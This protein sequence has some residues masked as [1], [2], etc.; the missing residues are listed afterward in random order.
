MEGKVGMRRSQEGGGLL[1]GFEYATG[2]KIEGRI[3]TRSQSNVYL[4]IVAFQ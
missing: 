1:I 3:V 2:A 4:Q